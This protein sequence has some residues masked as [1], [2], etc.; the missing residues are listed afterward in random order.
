MAH[1]V[2]QDIADRRIGLP[3]HF[4]AAQLAVDGHLAG[5][6][7]GISCRCAEDAAQVAAGLADAVA[8]LRRHTC[9]GRS[10]G[11]PG[12][13]GGGWHCRAGARP[14][15]TTPAKVTIAR[16]AERVVAAATKGVAAWHPNWAQRSEFGGLCQ[17]YLF[18]AQSNGI[19]KVAIND[20][21]GSG[22]IAKFLDLL[23]VG[24][25]TPPAVGLMRPFIAVPSLPGLLDGRPADKDKEG[26]KTDDKTEKP[27]NN[28][29]VTQPKRN[30][31][32]QQYEK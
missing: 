28:P 4:A 27:G 21:L 15:E 5:G 19:T 30:E 23:K 25:E 7:V 18:D 17:D 32:K 22:K 13:R 20:L 14:G 8:Q 11:L 3:F 10:F 16:K 26:D 29:S 2:I 31:T 24:L 12:G 9:K 6:T 1:D